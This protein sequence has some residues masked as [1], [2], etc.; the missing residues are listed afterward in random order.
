MPVNLL[1]LDPQG[2]VQFCAER[3]EKPFRARQ[4]M[5][6][7]HQ[8]GVDDFAAMTDIARCICMAVTLT[9]WPIGMREIAEA[10]WAEVGGMRRPGTSAPVMSPAGAP[11]PKDL[12]RAKNRSSP[13]RSA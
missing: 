4:L 1:D 12:I 5:H 11:K 10:H 3:G 9:E 13:C 6:W 8:S 7:I 2:F